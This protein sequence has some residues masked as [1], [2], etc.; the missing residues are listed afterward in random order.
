MKI[1]L[2]LVTLIS[3]LAVTSVGLRAADEDQTE[4]GAKMEKMGGAWRRIKAQVADASKNDD[5]LTK[6]GTMKQN[7]TAAL[8]LEPETAQS[9][10][11]A[12]K[13][14]YVA[15]FHA[16]IQKEIDRIDKITAAVKAGNNADA[17]KLVDEVDHD[18]KDAHKTYKKKKK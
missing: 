3:A 13:E 11:G 7:L 12:D 2:L 4:L 9:K 14:K 18:Y 16:R 15:E 1:R 10:S 8:Q 5:T 17:A 6:L